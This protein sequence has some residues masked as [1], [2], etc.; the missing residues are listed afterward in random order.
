MKLANIS[1]SVQVAEC[2]VRHAHPPL[3]CS[4]QSYLGLIA[5]CWSLRLPGSS[6]RFSHPHFEMPHILAWTSDLSDCR[7][8][9]TQLY[10]PN[11]ILFLISAIALAGF[12]PFGHVLEQFRI[13]WHRYKLMLFSKASFRSALRSSRLSASHL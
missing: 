4:F 13:V 10:E 6:T 5:R 7:F 8:P 12:S 9:Q 1:L 2:T 3:L 11:A